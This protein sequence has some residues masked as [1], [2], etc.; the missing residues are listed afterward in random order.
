MKRP[1]TSRNQ[2][3]DLKD[4]YEEA[5]Y[6]KQ[7]ELSEMDREHAPFIKCEQCIT[8]FECARLQICKLEKS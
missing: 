6:L 8:P 7:E 2:P 4:D 5:Y 1:R 3:P